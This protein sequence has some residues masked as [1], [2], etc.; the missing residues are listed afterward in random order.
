[1]T[2]IRLLFMALATLLLNTPTTFAQTQTA[3]SYLKQGKE[4]VKKIEEKMKKTGILEKDGQ[5]LCKKAITDFNISLEIEPSIEAYFLRAT[6]KYLL[7]DISNALIDY[8]NAIALD[9]YN[10]VAYNNRANLKD[11]LKKTV[12]A[13]KDY[14][15]AISLDSTYTNAYYNRG[16]AHYNVQ[17]YKEAQTDFEKVLKVLPQDATAM[18]GIGLCL[19]KQNRNTDACIWFT[20]AGAIDAK[21]VEDYLKKYCP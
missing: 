4:K 13:I 6:L 1:M 9:N 10:A 2:Y 8:D 15:K 21:L 11:E 5:D 20:K 14:D 17:E 18:L 12:E 19:V 16:I 7:N 3:E